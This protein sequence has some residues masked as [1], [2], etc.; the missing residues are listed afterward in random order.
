ML[1]CELILRSREERARRQREWL[2]RLGLPIVS[3]TLNIPGAN[4]QSALYR[5]I[6][7]EGMRELLSRLPVAEQQSLPLATGSEAILACRGDA[8]DIKRVTMALEEEHPLGRIFDMDVLDKDGKSLSRRDFGLESRRCLLCGQAAAVCARQQ[9]H[10]LAELL[11][12]IQK[13]AA[14]Y[15]GS[16]DEKP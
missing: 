7:D 9:S 16:T 10:P 1:A 3:F 5:R 4:K 11:E 2:S 13:T 6:H 14:A 8:R 12:C 15:F